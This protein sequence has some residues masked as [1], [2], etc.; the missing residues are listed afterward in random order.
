MTNT[1]NGIAVIGAGYWGKNLVRVFHQLGVLA[2]VCDTREEVLQ[3]IKSQ[4]PGVETTSNFLDVLENE[5]VSALVIATPAATHY[6]LTKQ[7]LEAQKHIFVEKPL[8]LNV[9]QGQELV[10]TAERKGLVFMVGHLLLYH[11]AMR[12]L[13]ELVKAG[14]LGELRYICSNRL[15]FGKLRK[16]ENVLWSFAPHDISIIIDLL[17]MPERVQ[18][19]GKSYLQSNVPD[20]TLTFLEFTGNKAAHIFVSWLNPFKEQKLS[21]IGSEKMAVYDGVSNTLT[22]FSHRV[23]WGQGNCPQAIGAEGQ[24]LGL[25]DEEPLMEEA[26]HFLECLRKKQTPIT[27]GKEALAVL[28]VLSASQKSLE[29]GNNHWRSF[30]GI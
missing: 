1:N 17:G 29:G 7:G 16:D 6:Q 5:K 4:Y 18:A 28:K 13:K 14:E 27:S 25:S 8:A 23:E 10:E 24:T 3:N 12:K 19:L 26:R 9:E 21:V 22:L 2:V 20:I 15:N 30:G 11:P